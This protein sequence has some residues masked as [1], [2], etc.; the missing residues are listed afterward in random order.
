MA[1]LS[2]DLRDALARVGTSTLTGVLNR[3]GLKSMTL[4][5]VWPLR[6]EQPPMVGIAFTMRF[7]PSREDKDGPTSTNRSA[8]QPQAMEECPP[9]H[10]LMI[11]SR[12]DS[13]AASAGDLYIGR[14]KARGA[15]GVVTDGGVRDAEMVAEIGLPV[16]S[17]GPHPAVLGRRHVP[18]ETDVTVACGGAAVQP[19]DVIV[20]DGDGVIVIPPPLVEEVLAECEAQER[21]EEWV[22]EQVA[23]GAAVDGLFPMNAEWRARFE[24]E[25]EGR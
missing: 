20:G 2:S 17:Q 23:G 19:G 4:F 8:I 12:G 13:R 22:A 10:V 11:D 21:E 7:I 5:D 24:R 25:A 3:R 6:P 15:A 9:G 1:V 14:L 16:F 18:W